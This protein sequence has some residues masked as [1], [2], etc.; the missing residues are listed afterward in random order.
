MDDFDDQAPKAGLSPARRSPARGAK[1][2]AGASA[3]RQGDGQREGYL[4]GQILIAMPGMQDERFVQS[5][6]C[7][8][9]HSI[10][11]AMGIVLNKPLDNISFE[12]LIR[13]LGVEPVPP[14]REIML[15]SGGPV[16][17]GRGFVLHT[18]D[19][20]CEGS[21]RV[22]GDLALT[23]SVDILKAFAE[24]GGPREGVLA[25]GYAGWGP[26][27]LEDEIQRNAWLS[28][29]ADEALIFG[30]DLSVKWREALARLRVDP[31]LLS[32]TAGHA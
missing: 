9:A 27:Q 5:I 26:G 30:R 20:T 1:P 4:S 22:A 24:G 21:L 32:S 28:V 18:A 25:L 31:L 11:G 8:C 6:I 10:D 13:Q 3:A 17:S 23:A 12:D 15:C 2:P 19:W 16:E 29:G 7:L 14:R